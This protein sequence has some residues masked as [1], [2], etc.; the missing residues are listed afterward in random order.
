[1][2]KQRDHELVT[3]VLN[4]LA[5]QLISQSGKWRGECKPPERAAGFEAYLSE[6][7]NSVITTSHDAPG[8]ENTSHMPTL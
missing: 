3:E 4:G 8:P 6:W 7:P 2:S 5:D 1:M